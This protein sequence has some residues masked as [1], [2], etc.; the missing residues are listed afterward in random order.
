MR[1]RYISVPSFYERNTL[2]VPSTLRRM[3][4][5]LLRLLSTIASA[6]LCHDM[7]CCFAL[8]MV[9]PLGSVGCAV[10]ATNIREVNEKREKVKR[11]IS[12]FLVDVVVDVTDRHILDL[13][14]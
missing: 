5:A 8:G 14:M 13:F 7:L 10:R 6:I 9:Y 1:I 12:R 3:L 4:S 2:L 11:K